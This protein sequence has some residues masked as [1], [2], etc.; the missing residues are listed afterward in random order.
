MKK[1]VL[2]LLGLFAYSSC[3]N[4]TAPVEE[5]ST[6][7]WVAEADSFLNA[8]SVQYQ[9][10]YYASSQAEWELNTHIVEGD[11][12]TSQLAESANENFAAFTGSESN[13]KAARKYLEHKED[14]SDIQNRQLDAIL[15]A[16]GA[17]PQT[18]KDIVSQKIKAETEQTKGLYGFEFS[19]D[20][21]AVS[22]NKI[23]GVLE[24]STNLAERLKAWEASKEVGIGLK[25]GLENLRGLRNKSVQAL[26]YEDFFQFQ[27]SEYGMSTQEMLDVNHQSIAEVWPLFREL[28]TWARYE[29]AEKY[30][31]EVPEYLPAHWLPN[32]WGQ[33]WSSMVNVDGLNFDAALE[34]KGNDWIMKQGEEFYMSL[35]YDALPESF[36]TKS[37]LYPLPEGADYKKNNHASAWHLDLNNDLRSLMSVEPNTRW[38][39]T[40]LHELGHIYYFKAYST[41][42]VP[43]VLRNGANRAYHE[44]IGTLIGLASMQKPFLVQKGLVQADLE[45]DEIQGLLKEALDYV[46]IMPWAS[47]VMTDFEHALYSENLSVDAFNQKWWELKKKY[48]G[49]VPPTER[50]EEFCD[51][52]SKTHINNDAAQY[53]DYA[54]A[55][56]LLFQFHMHIAKNI[57]KQDP[58]QTNYYGSKETGTFL[59]ALM[60]P[61]A[62]VDWK[63]NL[64]ENLGEGISAK[65]LLEYF[66]P[67]MAWLKKENE[68]RT[69]TLPEKMQ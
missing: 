42:Q 59:N 52:A 43:V 29:L 22:P 39:N 8:Y 40:V 24:S 28:H 65:A 3:Q 69:H 49:I 61:G 13:I 18:V 58:H 54:L 23:D 9:E 63:E 46:V 7:T 1:L 66:N 57:L 19:I 64:E 12:V 6:A 34:E 31:Q 45:V 62:T 36:Y 50:G 35:G 16:A 33:E 53:Y 15:Y 68:G 17:N 37:S 21:E 41:P 48:Q 11:T 10:L 32:R 26:G 55:N 4:N 2:G 38:W 67:L 27:V 51:A 20:G 25:P 44:A 14:L 60:K 30:G 56:V 5:N 47:G